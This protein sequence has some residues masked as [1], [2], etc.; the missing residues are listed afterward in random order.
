MHSLRLLANISWSGI[1]LRPRRASIPGTRAFRSLPI[2]NGYREGVGLTQRFCL[3]LGGTGLALFVVAGGHV[4]RRN[5]PRMFPDMVLRNV[6][7]I[8]RHA[9]LRVIHELP[10]WRLFP[11]VVLW[12]FVFIFM[13][14]V[15]LH[16]KGLIVSWK[17]SQ[18]VVWEKS[19]WPDTPA[20]YVR[21]PA[22]FFVNNQEVDRNDLRFK[23]TEQLG[24][25]AEWTVYFEADA[26]TTFM[27]AGYAIDVIQGCG[28]KLIWVTPKMREQWAHTPQS[29]PRS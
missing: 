2:R 3:F 11:V 17:K 8:A 26:D 1:F 14:F 18:A 20:V 12:I 24:R 21:A 16:S 29:S 19:P 27:D 6:L 13:I 5:L 7:P 23:L 15:P 28:A 4:A 22:R 10:Y 9:P 25:R